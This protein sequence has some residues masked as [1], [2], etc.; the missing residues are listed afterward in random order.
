MIVAALPAQLCETYVSE[1]AQFCLDVALEENEVSEIW[2]LGGSAKP[3]SILQE[4]YTHIKFKQFG[5]DQKHWPLDV[6]SNQILETPL[7][8]KQAFQSE[9][10]SPVSKVYL[11]LHSAAGYFLEM[12][13]IGGL[14]SPDLDIVTTCALPRSLELPAELI[15]PSTLKDVVTC[16]LE[17]I[18]ARLSKEFWITSSAVKTSVMKAL[19][20]ENSD[21]IHIFQES[22]QQAND[23]P[24]GQHVSTSHIIFDGPL[25]PVYGAD[26]FCD[27]AELLDAEGKLDRVTVV[28]S[29]PTTNWSKNIKKRLS[30]LKAN[31]VFTQSVDL[32]A[33]PNIDGVLIAPMRAPVLPK[34]VRRALGHGVNCIWGQGF[35]L[36]SPQISHPKLFQSIS[37]VRKLASTL[38]KINFDKDRLHPEKR[39]A[40]SVSPN[41]ISTNQTRTPAKEKKLSSVKS[42]SVIL[43]HHDRISQLAQALISLKA[44]TLEEFELIIIDDGS[45]SVTCGEIE[46][47]LKRFD[48]QNAHCSQ[49]EN[50]YPGAARNHGV[51][52]AKGDAVF[53][54]D[55]DNILD[56][57]TLESFLGAIQEQ[58][59]VLSFY[60]TF[61]D[62]NSPEIEVA[63]T[64]RP[65]QMG[66]SYSF[67]GLLPGSGLFY[68]ILGNSSFMMRREHF[69]ELGGFSAKYGVGL[70]DYSFMLRLSQIEGL[71]WVILP[72]PYLHFRLHSKKI[73]NTH[74]DWRSPF[75][76]QSGQ[77]RVIQDVSAAP[78]SLSPVSLAYARQLHEITQYHHIE[79]PRPKYF[80]L[81]S[82]LV[83]QYIRP[84]IAKHKQIRR[85]FRRFM[86]TESRLAKWIE[87]LL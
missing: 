15:L 71:K 30:K 78:L 68:N 12:A 41:G 5:L 13:S 64:L 66:L 85:I 77:W 25:S 82:I 43:L 40:A 62:D 53:F 3:S 81:K 31:I 87:K 20:L 80:R 35:D 74:V 72:E 75:P 49:I 67:A 34:S 32:T 8:L 56:P 42:V 58:E 60:Q 1:S 76:L 11:P 73:R 51:R 16:E 18:C 83:H 44:Q 52:L 65:N 36:A 2:I 21:H 24:D 46:A 23:G 50:S 28:S 7:I 33:K 6:G 59:I 4:K 61:F 86:G 27:L 54:L 70:E 19:S 38:R 17:T 14:L 22:A 63:K 45:N 10:T 69:L 48:F 9:N 84:A 55:D 57:R 47:L 29:A 37:D 39:S 26:A 79:R